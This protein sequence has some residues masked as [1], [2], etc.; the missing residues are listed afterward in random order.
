VSIS[1]GLNRRHEVALEI[2]PDDALDRV[3]EIEPP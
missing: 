2:G 1:L 3:V